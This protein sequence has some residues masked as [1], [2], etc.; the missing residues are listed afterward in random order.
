MIE[1]GYLSTV[2]IGSES[3]VISNFEN[4]TGGSSKDRLTGN[5]ANKALLGGMGN[6]ALI[7]KGGK[8]ILSGGSG[9]D[10]FFLNTTNASDSNLN[11]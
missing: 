2:I 8:D 4:I 7:G 9:A 3:D 11:Y 1:S 10:K 5:R 6:D